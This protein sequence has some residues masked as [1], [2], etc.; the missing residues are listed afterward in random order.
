MGNGESEGFPVP[1]CPYFHR[2]LRSI[3]F[4]R[5]MRVSRYCISFI[6]FLF[7]EGLT[8]C[9]RSIP[10][11]VIEQYGVIG[12]GRRWARAN[13][14][15]G[16]PAADPTE[17]MARSCLPPDTQVTSTRG[18]GIDCTHTAA[19]SLTRTTLHSPHQVPQDARDS[20]SMRNVH[21]AAFY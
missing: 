7:S 17:W 1:D 10:A 3:T 6:V 4:S 5:Y 20:G 2:L 13:L 15:S 19:S 16:R 9:N 8:P 11:G 21:L 18:D 14:R 12:S